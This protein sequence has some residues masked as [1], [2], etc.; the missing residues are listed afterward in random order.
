MADHSKL[1][2]ST[3]VRFCAAGLGMRM[4]FPDHTDETEELLDKIADDGGLGGT[5]GH[6]SCLPAAVNPEEDA[7]ESQEFEGLDSIAPLHG[8]NKQFR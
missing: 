3:S 2:Y 5:S 4:W 6:W 8:S 7:V 1:V